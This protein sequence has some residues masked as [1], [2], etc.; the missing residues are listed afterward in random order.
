MAGDHIAVCAENAP[1]VVAAAA[2]AL[3]LPLTACFRVDLPVGNPGGLPEPPAGPVTVRC[4][5]ARYAD[6]LSAPGKGALQALAA[7]ASDPSQAATL[8][9]LAS[10]DGRDAYHEYI[11][12]AKRSLL[13][14]L[15]DF[16]S[17][18]PSLGAFLG[19][20]A[21]RLQPR[22]YSIS[23]SPARHPQSVHITCAV[24][25]EVM[26]TGRLHNGVAS[27]W[28]AALTPGTKIPVFLRRSTFKLPADVNTPVVM[29]GP[30]TGL[31][32]FRGFIQER[33]VAA[34]RAAALG[35]ALLFFGC[36]SRQH[37][38]IYR[39]ELEGAVAGGALSA[40]HVAFSRETS[41]KDYVQH[42][43]QRQGAEVW[44]LLQPGANGVLYV[45]G[46]AKAMAKDVHRTLHDIIIK[47][48]GCSGNEAEARVKALSDSG[49]YLKDVW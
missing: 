24:V 35:P 23:S 1:E 27:S 30:G 9:Q 12:A 39:E 38:Y 34:K 20:I 3:G 47:Q 4:I 28:L 41:V 44:A 15:Q 40:L 46:D 43:M 42:H 37:D 33:L 21:P 11:V 25:Q 36:R 32:P 7:F 31:A 8:K 45:C 6:L 18:Q 48:T 29:V 19:S 10:I 16:P 49:R 14:V 5:L 22:F 17:A 13:E 26:P 2:K